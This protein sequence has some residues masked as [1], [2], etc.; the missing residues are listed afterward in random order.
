MH[1][2]LPLSL[3]LA[4]LTIWLVAGPWLAWP[5]LSPDV[6][7]RLTLVVCASA[8]GVLGCLNKSARPIPGEWVLAA[9]AAISVMAIHMWPVIQRA[10]YFEAF[11]ETALYC[12]GLLVVLAILWGAWG[13]LQLPL[14]WLRRLRWLGLWM[15]LLN[16]VLVVGQLAG[17]GWHLGAV[18]PGKASG[19]FHYDR[20]L[21]AYAVAWLPI[22]AI[23]RP[24]G[25]PWLIVL[26]LALILVAGKVTGWIG[27]AVAIVILFPKV[28]VCAVALCGV[29]ALALTDGTLLLKV[30]QRLL[31]WGHALQALTDRPLFGWTFGPMAES[32]FGQ[33]VGYLLPGLH[34]DW[35]A[36]MLGGGIPLGIVLGCAVARLLKTNPLSLWDRALQA[37]IA[38]LAVMALGQRVVSHAPIAALAV[39]FIAWWSREHAEARSTQS[40][41]QGIALVSS[42]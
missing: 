21:A 27:A 35:L 5:G 37:S 25:R 32:Q 7:Q 41:H 39:L 14:A 19:V 3:Q 4:V 24:W 36:L 34:S 9:L 31:T 23:W 26:P 29:A 15:L 38:A 13:M 22:L 8:I 20:L 6:S 10:G 16:G 1:R 12:D 33:E 40:H 42:R 17:W 2:L 28:R 18:H 11:Y 30:Q